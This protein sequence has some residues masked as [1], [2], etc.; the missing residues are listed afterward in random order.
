[1][2]VDYDVVENIN[3]DMEGIFETA[4]ARNLEYLLFVT[5]SRNSKVHLD[6]K[7]FE[8]KYMITTQ[9]V[10][11]KVFLDGFHNNKNVTAENI[12][13]K[14]NL[15]FGGLNYILESKYLN[16]DEELL[17]SYGVSSTFSTVSGQAS[18]KDI[19]F[20]GYA[21][22]DLANSQEFAGDYVFQE[23]SS[24]VD[25]NVINNIISSSLKRCQQ[26][27]GT[28]PKRVVVY[29]NGVSEGQRE[30][31]GNLAIICLY[32]FFSFWVW[33][34]PSFARSSRT[35]PVKSNLFL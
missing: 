28:T 12:I 13:N 14:V 8:R 3:Q 29:R 24:D 20:V 5:N 33:K 18:G 4:K 25:Y 27:R 30:Q 16:L 32:C 23:G 34:F 31:V 17:I 35:F 11:S 19:I 26:N 6:M 10:T 15:K 2:P 7:Y 1:M 21:A 9:N 22:N